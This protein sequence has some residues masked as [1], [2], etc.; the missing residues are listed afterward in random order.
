MRERSRRLNAVANIY[1][2]LGKLVGDRALVEF[3]SV[4][5][6]VNCALVIQ[7][8]INGQAQANEER[9]SPKIGINLGDVI[10]CPLIKA[11]VA[12]P[13]GCTRSTKV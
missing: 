7:R 2:R 8:A 4:V 10:G 3:G 1:G 6:T 11:F 9:I 5:D 13:P 12:R